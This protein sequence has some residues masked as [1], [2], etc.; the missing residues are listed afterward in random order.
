M[1]FTTFYIAQ[2]CFFGGKGLVFP[3]P[4]EG[5]I[6]RQ[7]PRHG[8]QPSAES[9]A[10][11]GGT[12]HP[13]ANEGPTLALILALRAP[14]RVHGQAGAMGVTTGGSVLPYVFWGQ[15]NRRV[16]TKPDLNSRFFFFENVS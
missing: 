9:L 5:G 8:P 13:L 16:E 1:I 11:R 14:A 2:Y 3:Q 12:T 7:N 10:Q 4:P 6:A 15:Q